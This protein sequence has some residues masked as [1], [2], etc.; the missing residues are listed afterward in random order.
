[1]EENLANQEMYEQEIQRGA[2]VYTTAD[3][4]LGSVY[5]RNQSVRSKKSVNYNFSGKRD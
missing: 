3:P 1:M 2:S 5:S 4:R